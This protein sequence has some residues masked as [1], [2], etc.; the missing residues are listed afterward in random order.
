LLGAY[1]VSAVFGIIGWNSFII[2]M[3]NNTHKFPPD[4][5][6]DG[7]E[8]AKK[9]KLAYI[10]ML[11]AF[12]FIPIL[13]YF[14]FMIWGLFLVGD[15]FRKLNNYEIGE[16]GMRAPPYQPS[17]SFSSAPS[18]APQSSEYGVPVSDVPLPPPTTLGSTSPTETA[19]QTP[20]F[21][22][23][24]G[25]PLKPGMKFCPKCGSKVISSKRPI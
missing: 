21:C 6:R 8:G 16:A 3:E 24:C 20:K 17:S 2:F 25:A 1:V 9:I 19:F 5:S 4:I 15:A 7:I 13:L 11:L 18:P 22:P 12:L 23:K 14:I 10:M